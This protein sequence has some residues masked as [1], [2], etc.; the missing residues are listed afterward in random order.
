MKKLKSYGSPAVSGAERLGVQ[1]LWTRQGREA[2]PGDLPQRAR[3]MLTLPPA[4]LSL[5]M[6]ARAEQLS[7]F[8]EWL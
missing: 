4:G 6:C 1:S 8:G 3:W 5:S 2:L 7:V